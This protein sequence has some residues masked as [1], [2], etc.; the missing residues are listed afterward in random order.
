[1]RHILILTLCLLSFTAYSQQELQINS[2]KVR[3]YYAAAASL[4]LPD[5]T[6]GYK[7]DTLQKTNVEVYIED[8]VIY[9]NNIQKTRYVLNSQ[10]VDQDFGETTVRTWWGVDQRGEFVEC[11]LMASRKNKLVVFASYYPNRVHMLY[12]GKAPSSTD[13]LPEVMKR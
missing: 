4:G 7:F 13:S 10:Y 1:M 6:G 8:T 2:K 9:M 11:R 3:V 12:M 5:G